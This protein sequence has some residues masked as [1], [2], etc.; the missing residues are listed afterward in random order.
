MKRA[1][2]II[3]AFFACTFIFGQNSNPK[4]NGRASQTIELE[5]GYRFVSSHILPDDPDMLVVLEEVLGDNVEFIRN[6]QGEIIQ[7]VGPNWINGIGDWNTTEGYL[8]KMT[9]AETL[10]LNG[11]VIDPATPIPVQAGYRFV[12]YLPAE[13]LDAMEAF[14]SII[15]DDLEFIRNMY[16][17]V[18]NKIGPNWINGIG[19]AQ[20]GEFYLVKML[21]DGELIYPGQSQPECPSTFTDPRD[22]QE[23][24]GV[25]IGDQCWMAEN[26][27]IGTM[28]P[29]E[30]DMQDNGTIEKYCY[31][32]DE[33]NC[34]EYGGLY[35]WDEIMQYTTQQGTQGICPPGWH[36]PTDEE[37]MML[38]GTVDSQ[39]GYPDPEWEQTGLRGFDAGYNLKSTSGWEGN[40]NG[41]DAF[42]FAGLPAGF[43]NFNGFFYYL[44]YS[45]TWWS[46]S[47]ANNSSA[48]GRSLLY[49]DE[50]VNRGTN[51]KDFGFSIR[52][53]KHE[54]GQ[55]LP[56]GYP[57]NPSPE[58]GAS[59][60]SIITTLSWEC[61]DPD[62]DPITYDVYF[63]MNEDPQQ[64]ATAI[65]E[66]IYD[67]G[68][69]EYSTT[70]YWKIVAH[71]DQGNTTEGLVWSFTTE[72][73]P[74]ECPASFT[75]PRDGQEYEAVLISTQCW[76][77]ENL[78]IGEMI[79][80]A[81]DMQDNGTIEKYCYDDDEANCDEY[82]GLY[83]WDEMM[84]YTTQQGTQGICPPG[85][86]IPID[87]EWMILEG[88]VDSQYGYPDPEWEQTGWRGYDAGYNLKSTNGWYNDGNGSD[89][90][91]YTAMPAGYRNANNSFYFLGYGSNW[92]SS[93]VGGDSTSAWGRSL[94]Y[95]NEQVYRYDNDK[96]FAF[97]MRCLKYETGQNQPPAEPSNPSPEDG[98]SAQSI[99]TPLSWECTDPDQDPITYDVYFGMNGNP[100]QV[101]TGLTET[102][103]VP[104]TLEFNTTY[105]WKII[106]HDDHA[107]TTEGPVWSFTTEEAPECPETYTDPR[108][109]Q[110]YEAV[111]IGNQCWM[112]EN[113]NIGSMIPGVDDMQDN[114]T[115]EKYCY[116]DDPVNCD[117]LGGL[118][119]WD[120]MMQYTT[121]QGTQGICPPG[122]HIP[123]DVEWMMLEGMVD[124]QYG[125][126]DPE[127]ETQGWRGFDAGYKL[128]STSGWYANG[129]G[130][131]A[132][133]FAALPAGERTISSTFYGI[134][135]WGYWW[136]SSENSPW[137][138]W[139]RFM[140]SSSEQVYRQY[141]SNDGGLS[142]RCLK[143]EPGQNLPPVYPF[144]P[145][146][147]DGASG[148][149]II[150]TLFWECTDP[151]QDPLTYDVY[152]G[153]NE[154]PQQV[155][156][157]I[158]ETIYG[159]DT[160]EYSTTYYWRI[161]AHDDQ[162]NTTEG[163]VWSFTTAEE[164]TSC[165]ATFTDPR[166]GQEYEA[167]Q[168]G[169]QCWMAENLNI[170]AMIPSVDQMQ[171]NGTLEKYCYD[172]DPVNCDTLGGLYLWGEMMQYTI[173][174]GTQ[175]I[176]PEGWHIP[177]DEE[178]MMLEGTVDS[179]YGYPDPEWEY[180]GSRG[181]DAGY[182]LK[183][184]SGWEDN[185]NGSDAFGFTG[186]PAGHLDSGGWFYDL[187]Y[188]GFWWSSSESDGS[189]AWYRY[190]LY[191]KE[192]VGR[193]ACSK[194]YSFYVRCLKND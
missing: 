83:Q 128:K 121:Q 11:D 69:L 123:T 133:G 182:N 190:L 144:N 70:Y 74:P 152:F 93:S 170:G 176:C 140:G 98:A 186:L 177:S 131:D 172:D 62:Q 160:L 101:A 134:G 42:G 61:T 9:G 187:G 99:I 12:S 57:F 13:P 106:A 188:Y 20:P 27:N 109:G 146:P 32:D 4:E 108:D 97:S 41:S 181:Y 81:D 46:S 48:W 39:Y 1:V 129:N 52:C 30:D 43:K 38:E 18:I 173:Q 58:D 169:D 191:H 6:A 119:Q 2:L 163:P 78:N 65:T 55:N 142:I 29:G 178:W 168:I 22:G 126:P 192:K 154:D 59:G 162:G 75:D 147:E 8:F 47:Q 64:V 80:G 35:Q 25:L 67:P 63:G 102:T 26:L 185:G 24:E 76:M 115:L 88:A 189:Y 157:A 114:D 79:P 68:T 171:D 51:T 77:A 34:Y 86:H 184:T 66:T 87:Q 28:I 166:D 73:E 53:L 149:S 85:W 194:D 10:T 60:Q 49:Y 21:G 105:Y 117:T 116:N 110:E 125:Y 158:T 104:G 103:Y 180:T 150:T 7:K 92:W 94:F 5:I 95:D 137:T 107:N 141:N 165:P 156:T 120:E 31:D 193:Y 84:Q 19:E 45:S 151:E 161:V 138:S 111:L 40:G 82:G 130:S 90:F 14:E 175:G 37:W 139:I 113:L 132:F 167:V 148:Q 3:A 71:D 122:W 174:Q 89:A 127:W 124:S 96:N 33:A 159:P 16:G 72:E 143:H 179:Q 112:A 91:G 136:S 164:T 17:N 54:P 100:Q 183:S 44:G 15:G 145:L 118:Y 135:Q 36:I 155:A 23:Y 153:M 56:P 50:Q